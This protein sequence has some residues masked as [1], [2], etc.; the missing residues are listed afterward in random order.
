MTNIQSLLADA[1]EVFFQVIYI[2]IFIRIL[3]SW[4][5][6]ARGS[7]IGSMIYEVTEPIMGPIRKMVAKSPIGGGMMLDFSP[8]IAL[9]ILQIAK[10]VLV[11]VI[12]AF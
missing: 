1:V 4:F 2:L 12:T 3:L 10:V 6:G 9:F 7:G 11:E 5:P 8:L